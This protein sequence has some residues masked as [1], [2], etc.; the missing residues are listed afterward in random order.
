MEEVM[1]LMFLSKEAQ[2]VAD[3]AAR[4]AVRMITSREKEI[5]Q[6]Q[7]VIE[8]QHA[9]IAV[10]ERDLDHEQMASFMQPMFNANT[11]DIIIKQLKEVVTLK[12]HLENK[13]I[14]L[15]ARLYKILEQNKEIEDLKAQLDQ[16]RSRALSVDKMKT[17]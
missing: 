6:L 5:A 14:E 12:E 13:N 1:G 2:Q 8:D 11:T 9:K 7:E 10:L 17:E 15:D 3:T 16:E 4:I